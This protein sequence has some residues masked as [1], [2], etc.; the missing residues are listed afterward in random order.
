[1]FNNKNHTSLCGIPISIGCMWNK[2]STLNRTPH[3]AAAGRGKIP[4]GIGH[5][6]YAV[7]KEGQLNRQGARYYPI[8]DRERPCPPAG[9]VGQL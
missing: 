5:T 9:K 1:M 4:F 7:R 2:G 3:H 6:K 8:T